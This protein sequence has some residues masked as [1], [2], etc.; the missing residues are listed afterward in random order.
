MIKTDDTVIVVSDDEDPPL[1][2]IGK[3]VSYN[4]EIT[5]G[6]I[7]Y[8]IKEIG[9]RESFYWID[10]C[11]LRKVTFEVGDIV[12]RNSDQKKFKIDKLPLLLE[13][14][15]SVLI[16]RA[17]NLKE[18][19]YFYFKETEITL[20]ERNNLPAGYRRTEEGFLTNDDNWNDPKN[21]LC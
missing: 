10:S 12:I 5:N 16:Y 11:F 17:M 14:N 19:I 21:W 13:P 20:S 3:V 2:Y 18:N 8:L 4:Y 1:G 15:P 9:E 6:S 7:S